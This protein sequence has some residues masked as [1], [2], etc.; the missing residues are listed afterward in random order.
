MPEMRF[1]HRFLLFKSTIYKKPHPDERYAK[2][3][4]LLGKATVYTHLCTKPKSKI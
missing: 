1:F 2:P 4:P 3:V